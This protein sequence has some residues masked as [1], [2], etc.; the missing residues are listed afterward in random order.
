MFWLLVAFVALT[1]AVD[2]VDFPVCDINSPTT[3]NFVVSWPGTLCSIIAL[4]VAMFN[5][6]IYIMQK[7]R[8]LLF[9]EKR[10][11]FL[12]P[13]ILQ[14]HSSTQNVKGDRKINGLLLLLLAG[15]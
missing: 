3:K 4:T 10:S 2:S 12:R 7:Q 11:V 1:H 9:A 13:N 8:T 14:Q 5:R 15:T 6:F